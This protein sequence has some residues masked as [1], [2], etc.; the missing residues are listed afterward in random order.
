MRKTLFVAF[1]VK[2]SAKRIGEATYWLVECPCVATDYNTYT[3]IKQMINVASKVDT[4]FSLVRL[5][6]FRHQMG[7]HH[8]FENP[9]IW[10]VRASPNPA[11]MWG[12]MWLSGLSNM[13]S[14]IHGPIPTMHPSYFVLYFKPDDAHFSFVIS[15][16]LLHIGLPQNRPDPLPL[17]SCRSTTTI[18]VDEA[19]AAHDTP[20][21]K[22]ADLMSLEPLSRCNI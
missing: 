7:A 3:W 21:A 10:T 11:H 13:L 12:E 5:G 19:C 16:S 20:W 18:K 6:V 9:I 2:Q 17:Y 14:P 8:A 4:H 15:P 22:K 1:C